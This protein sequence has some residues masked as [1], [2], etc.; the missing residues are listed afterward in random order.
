M[1]VSK[2][3]LVG[4]A[5]GAVALAIVA[6]V[7]IAGSAEARWGDRDY[8]YYD[9]YR[10]RSPPVVYYTPA[11][12]YYYY[13]PPVVYRPGVQIYTPGIGINIH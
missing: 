9:S 3:T 12:R 4:K 6:A 2:K 7:G 13:P 11:P 8:R 10:Y 1:S 5:V